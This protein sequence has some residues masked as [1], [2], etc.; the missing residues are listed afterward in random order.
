MPELAERF[1]PLSCNLRGE[2][3]CHTAHQA[4]TGRVD[5]SIR[6]SERPA[7]LLILELRFDTML[8]LV[9]K[10]LPL[11]GLSDRPPCTLGTLPLDNSNEGLV[12]KN[13]SAEVTYM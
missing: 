7:P 10:E 6:E 5:T 11:F 1:D 3:E 8:P 4:L 13:S 9:I 12:K 2:I